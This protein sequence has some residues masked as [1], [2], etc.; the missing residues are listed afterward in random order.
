[1]PFI[2]NDEK[3]SFIGDDEA[4]DASKFYVVRKLYVKMEPM[5]N[6]SCYILRDERNLTFS[7]VYSNN[8]L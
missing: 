1:M 6:V 4:Y 7:F 3:F 8:T 2:S 5:Y